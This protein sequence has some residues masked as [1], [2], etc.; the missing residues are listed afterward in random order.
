MEWKNSTK[1]AHEYKETVCHIQ[2][3]ELIKENQ[4]V[5]D[6]Y[7]KFC[8]TQ[9][10]LPILNF[11]EK[12]LHLFGNMTSNI[13]A[14]KRFLE[15]QNKLLSESSQKFIDEHV[16]WWYEAWDATWRLYIPKM[17]TEIEQRYSS[18]KF[19]FTLL[20]D[21]GEKVSIDLNKY[22][23]T[24]GARTKRILRSKRY[25][26]QPSYW[27][28]TPFKQERVILHKE[29]NEY[30]AVKHAFDE[31]M[32]EH[33][34]NLISIERI[35]N[36]C[37][38]KQFSALHEDYIHKYGK[39]NN[40]T[41]RFLYHGCPDTAAKR[42]M[43][44]GFNRSYCGLNGC[45]YGRGVYFSSNASYSDKYATPDAIKQKRIFYSRVLIGKSMIG[46]SKIC[47]PEDG[48]DTTTD[49]KH[50]F[51]CYHDSQVK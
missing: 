32:N 28:L 48:Y 33:Y 49:G 29:S 13:E 3:D 14:E 20:N 38:F 41:M 35:Q 50:I 11:N 27:T 15:L 47:E 39:D 24:Y 34:T 37:L 22:V 40:G 51:V 8:S 26:H 46:N 17:I 16:Y 31:T 42:I 6:E 1:D 4:S 18:N 36:L 5:L 23:E 45:V 43:E 9:M 21:I 7:L 12:K 25:E 10:V 44:R 19:N 30:L 2:C